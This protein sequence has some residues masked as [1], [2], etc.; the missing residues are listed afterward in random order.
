MYVPCTIFFRVKNILFICRIAFMS[1]ALI[2][3]DASQSMPSCLTFRTSN[4]CNEHT[5]QNPTSN[6]R[7]GAR[8]RN[9]NI[10]LFK[11]HEIRSYP[12]LP[13]IFPLS[14]QRYFE[15]THQ[16]VLA[17]NVLWVIVTNARA[18][19]MKNENSCCSFAEVSRC[20]LIHAMTLFSYAKLR[21]QKMQ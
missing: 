14:S 10:K 19:T 12:L 2:I 8:R 18:A 20:A 11:F 4:G 21:V 6:D 7:T 13:F 17:V 3:T 15:T 16:D 9:G 1:L 5:E